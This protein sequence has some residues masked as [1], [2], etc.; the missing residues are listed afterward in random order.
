MIGPGDYN[1]LNSSINKH[2]FNKNQFA[3]TG[4]KQPRFDDNVVRP[5]LGP[6]AYFSND[7]SLSKVTS[8]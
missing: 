2:S 5:K 3:Y 7:N 8:V 6:G 4:S 1:L